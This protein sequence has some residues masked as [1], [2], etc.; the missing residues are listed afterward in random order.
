MPYATVINGY[1]TPNFHIPDIGLHGRGCY[2]ARSHH[3]GGAHHAML[4]GS[5]QFIT[6][7]INR[8]L[9]H[10]LFTRNGREVVEWPE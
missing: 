2:A 4:D 8:D 5:V 7:S 1:M 3:T 10:A 9:Y 6:D